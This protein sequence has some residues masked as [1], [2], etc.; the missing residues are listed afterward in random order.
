MDNQQKKKMQWKCNNHYVVNIVAMWA[1]LAPSTIMWRLSVVHDWLDLFAWKRRK[2]RIFTA[3]FSLCT[4]GHFSNRNEFRY[5]HKK[6]LFL[7]LS[8]SGRYPLHNYMHT[9]IITIFGCAYV[10]VYLIIKIKEGKK[11]TANV[12]ITGVKIAI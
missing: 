7:S 11:W 1:R 10:C 2:T 5:L 12:E 9:E 6:R 4:F 3:C 8:K